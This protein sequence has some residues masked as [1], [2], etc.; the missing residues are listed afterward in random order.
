MSSRGST[1]LAGGAGDRC[2]WSAFV[3]L[4]DVG[5]PGVGRVGILAELALGATLAQQVPAAIQLD[6]DPGQPRMLVRGGD[7]TVGETL[8]K[9]MLFVDEAADVLGERSVIG[10]GHTVARWVGTGTHGFIRTEV[11]PN[12]SAHNGSA[13]VRPRKV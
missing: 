8:T 5:P 7:L 13:K 2:R 11:R 12:G 6:L 10:H 3:A 4:D 1:V 9:G